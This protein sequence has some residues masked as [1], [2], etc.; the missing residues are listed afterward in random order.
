M[1]YNRIPPYLIGLLTGH[2]LYSRELRARAASKTP[3]IFLVNGTESPVRRVSTTSYTSS[4][5]EDSSTG[6]DRNLG[7]TKD[8]VEERSSRRLA[9]SPWLLWPIITLI[10]IIYLPLATKLA[11]QHGMAAKI[12]SSSLMAVMR[13]AWSLAIARLIFVCATKQT[14]SLVSRFLSSPLWKP[15]SKVGLSALLI[16]WEI[17]IYLAQTQRA[18]PEM[19][20]VFLLGIILISTV[21]T[22]L[23]AVP[24]H[25]AY[26]SPWSIIERLYVHP[27]FDEPS[28]SAAPSSTT[29]SSDGKTTRNN[30]KNNSINNNSDSSSSSSSN[31]NSSKTTAP[32]NV[33]MTSLQNGNHIDDLQS[34]RRRM[35]IST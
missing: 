32:A 22:Y 9:S 35:T 2:F 14:S 3:L 26:E 33:S 34:N 16:Q 23:L 29:N 27:I 21:V 1:P 31:S 11:S 5:S 8:R 6:S 10:S 20:I 24:L 18:L 13:L 25:L 30:N 19:N 4:T 17:I 15:W 28:I 12:V 7:A